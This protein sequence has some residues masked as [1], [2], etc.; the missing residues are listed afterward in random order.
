[1]M[2]LQSHKEIITKFTDECK[3]TNGCPWI[4]FMDAVIDVLSKRDVW[5]DSGGTALQDIRG[6][7]LTDTVIDTVTEI[8]PAT[9]ASWFD[10]NVERYILYLWDNFDI[11]MKVFMEYFKFLLTS[12]DDE[13]RESRSDLTFGSHQHGITNSFKEYYL[14]LDDENDI[15]VDGWVSTFNIEMALSSVS[16][17]DIIDEGREQD[18]DSNRDLELSDDEWSNVDAFNETLVDEDLPSFDSSLIKTCV[19]E[20]L[21][22]IEGIQEKDGKMNEGDYLKMM[23]LC[24]MI[25]DNC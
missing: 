12:F 14:G 23:D 15:V 1:M 20:I 24:K 8:K 13:Y 22:K 3:A 17:I 16:T 19:G 25:Y 2:N 9:A 4:L 18:T 6:Y 21:Q 10:A 11:N 7:E 5:I